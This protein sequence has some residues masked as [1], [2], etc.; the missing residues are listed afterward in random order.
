MRWR[1]PDHNHPIVQR[2]ERWF[3]PVIRHP[4]LW[5]F[6]RHSAAK[7]VAI[8]VFFAF[9]IPVLQFLAAGIVAVML[10]A[11]LPLALASTLITNPITFPPVF[12]LAHWIGARLGDLIPAGTTTAVDAGLWGS[13]LGVGATTYVGLIVL[14]VASSAVAYCCA[15]WL[16]P[17][18]DS[19]GR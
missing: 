19:R 8:G 14:A 9:A 10:R 17:L 13:V 1:L 12:V 18:M 11:N 4:E 16:W 5:R 6:T 2:L 3:G 7:A 15:H